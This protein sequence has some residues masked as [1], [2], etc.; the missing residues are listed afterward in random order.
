M[1]YRTCVNGEQIFGNGEY[2]PEWIEFIKSQGIEVDEDGCYEGDITDFMGALVIIENIVLRLNKEREED[3]KKRDG[4]T[5]MSIESLFDFSNIPQK[6]ADPRYETS[7]LD[8]LHQLIENS[9]AFMPY[10]FYQAC[11]EQLVRDHI[12]TTHNHFF[13]YKLK[14]EEKIHVKAS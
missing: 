13:C 4:K 9:Y 1:S 6:I 7:L 11:E 10:V 2:Y 14:D 3:K 5:R 8:E 12:Y